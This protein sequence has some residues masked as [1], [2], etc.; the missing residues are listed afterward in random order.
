MANEAILGDRTHSSCVQVCEGALRT[1]AGRRNDLSVL[2][3]ID[4]RQGK[5]HAPVCF[6]IPP[7]RVVR[8]R[9]LSRD[10]WW[11]IQP[12]NQLR[13]FGTA[14]FDLTTRHTLDNAT[15]PRNVVLPEIVR[16]RY[17]QVQ[18]C[19]STL[20]TRGSE[21]GLEGESTSVRLSERYVASGTNVASVPL[22][23][24]SRFPS[25][26]SSSASFHAA[27]LPCPH[28]EKSDCM[29]SH[30]FDSNHCRAPRT[31]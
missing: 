5:I 11:W 29:K 30:P 12:T 25:L 15:Q 31:W 9:S 24:D 14:R 2:R 27:S 13:M 8:I 26:T 3:A 28:M 4:D 16:R 22:R 6:S 19:A 10:W 1:I 21:R 17:E 7:I 23:G 18:S 20:S